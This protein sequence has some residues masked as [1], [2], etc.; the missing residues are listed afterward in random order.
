MMGPLVRFEQRAAAWLQGE[1]SLGNAYPVCGVEEV[2]S[3]VSEEP[4]LVSACFKP[5]PRAP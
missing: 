4:T 3:F 2:V 1:G 5:A